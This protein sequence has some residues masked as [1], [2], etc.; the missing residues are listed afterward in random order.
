MWICIVEHALKISVFIELNRTVASHCEAC[1]QAGYD[2]I[3]HNYGNG[4]SDKTNW[5][6]N[7]TKVI[8]VLQKYR[9]IC[10]S[11]IFHTQGWSGKCI[12]FG[13]PFRKYTF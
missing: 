2:T 6:Y 9:Y 12:I 4:K 7:T 1:I 10:C 5:N 11:L 13:F 8:T 3:P